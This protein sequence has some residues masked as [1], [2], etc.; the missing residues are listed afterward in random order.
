VAILTGCAFLAGA[1]GLPE[2]VLADGITEHVLTTKDIVDAPGAG[3]AAA[4][5]EADRMAG[6]HRRTT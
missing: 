6:M 5:A 4:A 3:D 1:T 2:D